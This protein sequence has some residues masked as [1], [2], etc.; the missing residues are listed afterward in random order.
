MPL[1]IQID[2]G[3]R[4]SKYKIEPN[5]KQKSDPEK[6]IIKAIKLHL[7]DKWKKHQRP[8]PYPGATD[9]LTQ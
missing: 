8:M 2:S 1:F 9:I 5:N 4:T 7:W 6:T 3:V